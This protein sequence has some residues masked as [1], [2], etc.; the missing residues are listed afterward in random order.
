MGGGIA[1]CFAN[2]GI[3]VRLLEVEQAA[4]DQ[5]LG[6]IRANY[7]NTVTKGRLAAAEAHS[8]LER[9]RPSLDYAD[10]R[11]VDLVIE[12]VFEDLALK[13]DIFRKLDQVCKPEAILATNTSTLDVNLIASVTHR[14][15]SVVGMH[16]F[17]PANVM[18]LLENVRGSHTSADIVATVMA[19]AKRIGKVGVVVG[20]CYGFVGNRMLHQRA[21]EA[22]ALVNEGATPQQVDQVLTDFGFPMGHFAMSDLAGNDVGWRIREG[23]RKANDPQAPARNWLDTLVEQGRLGQKTSAGVFRYEQGSRKPLPDPQVDAL[24]AN[25]RAEA[26][27]QSRP[28]SDQEILERCL[29]VMVNEGAKILE[30]GIAA[31]SRDIDV[32]WQYGYGFPAYR[33]GPM[34][35]ADQLGLT[36]VYSTVQRYHQRI[37]GKQWR[38]SELLARLAREGKTFA[39]A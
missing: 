11:D 36:S 31:R 3:A 5:G 27:I 6:V 26:G 13:Q 18:R 29:T 15:E 37:G 20:V 1:M 34:F 8:R 28:V 9:I 4:L 14:P 12:A 24:I 35:W 7:Q 39:T 32:I 33:G 25:Y 2:A 23:R 30:E 38:P 22:I 19:L 17:S 10:L 21:T 16:F